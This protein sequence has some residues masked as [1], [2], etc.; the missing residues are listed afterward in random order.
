MKVI[1]LVSQKGGVGKTTLT[2]H[3]GIEAES[4][5]DGPV[6]M[7]DT[8]PQGSL[9]AWWNARTVDTP[10]FANAHLSA[11]PEQIN[12]LR[13]AGYRHLLID[14]PP[15]MTSEIAAVVAQA[16]LV[17]VPVKP[18]PHDLRAVGSTVELVERAGKPFLFV[19]TM[20]KPSSRLTAQAIAALSAHGPVAPA[21]VGDRVDFAASMVDGRSV[22]ELDARSKSAGEV[23]DLWQQVKAHLARPART[24]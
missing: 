19:V 10:A 7:M 17:V 13:Q 4:A 15:A 21:F 14:T 5:G 2:G 18:S 12:Q 3:F 11:L 22:R 9:A 23:S 1:V 20:A 24:K 8:D 6:V 16:D